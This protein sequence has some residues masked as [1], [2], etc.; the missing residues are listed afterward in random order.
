[1]RQTINDGAKRSAHASA[2]ARDSRRQGELDGSSF[3]TVVGFLFS[4]EV[5][6][7]A[8]PLSAG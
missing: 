5:Y 1:M 2:N 4:L 3:R 8:V 6:K 7:L